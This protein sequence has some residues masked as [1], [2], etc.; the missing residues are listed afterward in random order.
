M[1]HRVSLV[2]RL[3]VAALL[4]AATATSAQTTT[5]A[6][7][8]SDSLSGVVLYS[9]PTLGIFV[10]VGEET[11]TIR[12]TQTADTRPGDRIRAT[13][14]RQF[15]DGR[16]FLDNPIRTRSG[17]GG[18]P[19]ARA[20]AVAALGADQTPNDWVEFEATIREVNPVSGRTQLL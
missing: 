11:V 12:S 17:P 19:A 15:R 7:R 1:R 5:P 13:G 14:I 16:R 2:Q 3:V 18:L 4:T 8:P 6:P 9:D 10:Q 20:V